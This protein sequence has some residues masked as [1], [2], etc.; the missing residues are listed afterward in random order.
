MMFN[1]MLHPI[2]SIKASD[3]L[4]PLLP[5]EEPSLDKALSL[6]DQLMRERGIYCSPSFLLDVWMRK[7]KHDILTERGDDDAQEENGAV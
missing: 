4:I 5:D 2:S 7:Q 3:L 1:D 6:A